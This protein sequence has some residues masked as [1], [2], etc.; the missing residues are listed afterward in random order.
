[1]TA[2]QVIDED[3]IEIPENLAAE[4]DSCRRLVAAARKNPAPALQR[5]AACVFRAVT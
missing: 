2:A 3:A 5:G 1:M 4:L